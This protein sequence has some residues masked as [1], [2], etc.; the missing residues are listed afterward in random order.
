MGKIAIPPMI[1]HAAQ[2]AQAHASRLQPRAR[3]MY[4]FGRARAQ[5]GRSIDDGMPRDG[6]MAA[7]YIAGYNSHQQGSKR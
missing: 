5:I 1:Q 7:A 6:A 2:A 3:R 4:E